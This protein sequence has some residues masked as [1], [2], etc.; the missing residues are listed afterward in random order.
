V[1]DA[2][3]TITG[4]DVS[5]DLASAKVFVTVQGDEET[6]SL[7]MEGL[8]RASGF[9]RKE[10]GSELRLRRI[11]RLEFVADESF[12][13]ADKIDRLLRNL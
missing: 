12:D 13:E 6:F 9:L 8:Q 3:Y 2:I 4:V 1:R 5:S 11:P 10:L 7:V